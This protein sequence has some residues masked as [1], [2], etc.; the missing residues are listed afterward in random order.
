MT[1][2]GSGQASAS[3][4]AVFHTSGWVR[5]PPGG[6]YQGSQRLPGPWRD[7][8]GS[9]LIQYG[10]PQEV[11]HSPVTLLPRLH[12]IL[13]HLIRLDDTE[14]ILLLQYLQHPAL[15]G[16]HAAC[17]SQY[18]LTARGGCTSYI[19]HILSLPLQIPLFSVSSFLPVFPTWHQTRIFPLPLPLPVRP[20][21]PPHASSYRSECP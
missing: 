18:K 12:Q 16:P 10:R 11:H 13:C 1:T 21:N 3:P 2:R 9:V 14:A 17:D 8:D 19:F 15:A 5:R 7:V 4:K 20:L 6:V